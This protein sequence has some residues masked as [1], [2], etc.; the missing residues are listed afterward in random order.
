MGKAMSGFYSH[1]IMKESTAYSFTVG[2]YYSRQSLLNKVE[3]VRKSIYR[4]KTMNIILHGM[5]YWIQHFCAAVPQNP[6]SATK[7]PRPLWLQ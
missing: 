5:K 7:Y 3:T 4:E 6:H 2:L 1:R